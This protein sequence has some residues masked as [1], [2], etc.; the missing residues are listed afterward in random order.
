MLLD[1]VWRGK[2]G[3]IPAAIAGKFNNLGL[4]IEEKWPFF[5]ANCECAI[6]GF[7]EPDIFLWVPDLSAVEH[8]IEVSGKSEIV[9]KIMR[10]SARASRKSRRPVMQSNIGEPVREPWAPKNSFGMRLC[11]RPD[12]PE[13]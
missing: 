8:T 1:I 9:P 11:R 12:R 3:A 7:E 13:G 5:R 6:N 2:D 10:T 4:I